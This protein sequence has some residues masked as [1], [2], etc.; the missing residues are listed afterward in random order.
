MSV[1]EERADK[2]MTERGMVTSRSQAKSMI[3]KG[4]VTCNGEVLKKAGAMIPV[5]A[6]ILINAPLYVGRGAFKLENAFK[7][8]KLDITDY[9]MLDV[10][11]STG[12]FTEIMLNNGAKKVYAIDVGH[13]QLAAKLVNDSRVI[14]MEGTN[15]RE[16]NELPEL[17]DGAVMDLSFISVTKVI[18]NVAKLLKPNSYLIVL[19]KPQFEAGQNRVPHH[20]VI[21]DENLRQTV[22]T[23]VLDFARANGWKNHKV[24]DSPLDGK[25]GNREFLALWQKA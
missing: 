13:G 6:E 10:G 2:I 8:F 25:T 4:D 20:G 12:G 15:I 18:A 17:A 24:I 1:I 7:E 14:N 5:D 16:L 9:V 11:A 21:R 3:D 23:E 22:L 19:I